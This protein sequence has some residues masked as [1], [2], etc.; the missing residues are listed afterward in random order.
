M[1]R[2]AAPVRGLLAV[3]LVLAAAA[4][5]GLWPAP[6]QA[7]Q[8]GLSYISIGTWTPDMG[9]GRVHV[10]LRILATSHAQDDGSRRYYFP[11]LQL[12]LPASTSDF[13]ATDDQ[14]VALPVRVMA[15][16]PYGVVVYAT[17]RQRLY[18]GQTGSLNFDFDLVDPGGSTD[19]DLHIGR[20]LASFPVTAF[21]S[22][23]AAGSSVTVVFPAGYSVQEQFGN[24]TSKV[25]LNGETVYTTGQVEDATEVN[26][27]F[28][29][30]R[31]DPSADH[32]V[33]FVTVAPLQVALRYWADDPGWADQ[34]E[35]I[36]LAGYPILRE[37]IGR[38]DP[39]IRSL[40]LEESTIQGIGGFSGEY[41]SSAGV[42]RISYFAD[43]MVILHELAHLWFDNVLASDRWINEGFASYYAEQTI[44][45]LGLPD[46]APTLS[47]ALMAA[48]VPLND[49]VAAGDPGS[50]RE[51]YL[52]AA[53]LRAAKEIA[54][55]V[56]LTRL[57]QVWNWARSGAG[58]YDEPPAPAP[59]GGSSGPPVASP[60]PGASESPSEGP[61]PTA[62]P[63]S[64]SAAYA[65]PPPPV[66][67]GPVAPALDWRR[68]LDYLD[69][70]SGASLA[71]VFERWVVT[72][73]QSRL[74]SQRDR[75][76]SDYRQTV[77]LAAGW[78][79]PPDV[80]LAMT[81]WQFAAAQE[82]L[83]QVRGVLL[84]RAQIEEGSAEEATSPPPTLR[85]AFEELST[86]AAQTEASR[87]LGV[88]DQL[89]AAR[90]ARTSSDGAARLVGLLGA[91]PDAQ[92][93][94]AREAFA[95]GDLDEAANLAAAARSAWTGAAGSGQVRLFGA[96][97][98]LAGLLLLLMVHVSRRREVGDLLDEDG[99]EDG[100]EDGGM[101]A[102]GAGHG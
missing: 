63:T 8:S 43:P 11:G 53:S 89:A 17:F 46:H 97:M 87:E 56:G 32:E 28:T 62:T 60:A 59:P 81:N 41:D 2:R 40:T 90:Q 31:F 49:W 80:T 77:D 61:T 68:L 64:P 34:V 71:D 100:A 91:D 67:T 19:R 66:P 99:A 51:A 12:T 52:Y 6:V 18:A 47:G 85:I 38:G 84:S 22:P 9:A 54:G 95:G 5:Q 25:G 27:W 72:P 10:S 45:E 50:A 35:R 4:W 96:A 57:R 82:L 24:L 37:M 65:S 13:A 86:A 55:T 44:L 15:S 7:A 23:G 83:A 48:A 21:G 30:S 36:L 75:A 14:G 39:R 26:A 33:R 78:Q 74:L 70:A 101:G 42:I 98:S 73:E 29:A 1:T 102:A 58:P 79:M 93:A 94:A 20:D 69:Q 76:L 88:L 92:L 16:S 3:A